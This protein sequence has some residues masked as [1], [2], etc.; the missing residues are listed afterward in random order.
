MVGQPCLRVSAVGKRY[1]GLE[2]LA[3]ITLDVREGV[4]HAILGPNGA[5]KTTLFKILSGEIGPSSGTISFQG[6]DITQ[7]PPYRRA[8]MGISRTFQVTTL[9]RRLTTLEN[10]MLAVQG[11]RRTKYIPYRAVERVAG[12]TEEAHHLLDQVGLAGREK[13]LVDSLAYGEQR[14]LEIGLALAS[15]PSL[16]LLDEPTAGLARAEVTRIVALLRGLPRAITILF[17]EHD[18][19]VAFALAETVTVLSQGQIIAEGSLDAIR[20]NRLVQE[21]Y[22]GEI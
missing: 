14:Q 20:A 19:D 13:V 15:H 17:I 7:S 1:G 9:F 2:A 8:A 16:L 11:T 5:G 18:M 21:I 6:Q 3:G 4:R 12:L 10:V 22:L